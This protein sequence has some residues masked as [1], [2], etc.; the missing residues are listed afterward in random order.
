MW[1]QSLLPYIT[2]AVVCNTGFTFKSN[3]T[4]RQFTEKWIFG[5]IVM[6]FI[7]IKFQNSF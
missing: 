7:L 4:D 2:D 5:I 3:T 6:V 1:T